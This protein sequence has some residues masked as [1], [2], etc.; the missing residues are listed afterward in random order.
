MGTVMPNNDP[1][2]Q[3]AVTN[4]PAQGEEDPY[5]QYA[6][7]KKGY[8][9]ELSLPSESQNGSSIDLDKAAHSIAMI[10]SSGNYGAIGQPVHGKRAIGKYQVME[11][12]IPEWSKEVLGKP[13]TVEEFKNS[14]E[15]QDKIVKG[16]I[17][18]L[19]DSGHSLEDIPS[20][21]LSGQPYK[22]N[23]RKDKVSGTNVP[24]YVDKFMG[25]YNSKPG[26]A[27]VGQD[28]VSGIKN[29]PGDIGGTFKN[30][31]GEVVGAAKQL[32]D[33]KR[34]F[35]NALTG[36]S[37]GGQ[38]LANIIPNTADYL[39]EKGFIGEDNPV[40]QFRGPK[41]DTPKVFG[42]Q[43]E[44]PGD[45]FIRMLASYVVP[46]KAGELGNFG[47]AGRSASRAGAAG[48]YSAGEGQNVAEGAALGP[49]MEAAFKGPMMAARGVQKGAS[50]L[51]PSSFLRGTASPED[52]KRNAE[53]AG[54]SPIPL[55]D[56][57]ESPFTKKAF[58]N[59]AAEI[60]GSGASQ[61]FKEVQENVNQRGVDVMKQLGNDRPISVDTNDTTKDLLQKAKKNYQNKKNSL[62]TDVSRI[63]E[64]EGFLPDFKKFSSLANK[65]KSSI[66]KSP[67]FETDEKLRKSFSDILAYSKH[68]GE[69]K[70]PYLSSPEEVATY[71]QSVKEN[72]PKPKK[73]IT[74][75]DAKIMKAN[76]Y[77][78]GEK[79]SKSMNRKD[80]AQG[81]LYKRLSSALDS[82]IKSSIKEKGSPELQD[83][84]AKAD[85]NYRESF[86][87]TLDRDIHKFLSGDKEADSIVR[88][89]IRPSK[90]S[91][92]YTR[93]K[94]I[95]EFL[96]E[97]DKNL[98]GYTYL[99][100][101]FE[102]DGT[103]NPKKLAQLVNSLGNRQFET[104]FP[105]PKD[106][107]ALLDYG[108]LR[109]MSE[110]SLNMMHNPKTGARALSYFLSA[111]SPLAGFSVGGL[112][113]VAAGAA[114]TSGGANLLTKYLTSP[115]VRNKLVEKMVKKDI[116]KE[117]LKNKK[118]SAFS[119][120]L[121]KGIQRGAVPYAIN[122]RGN[123]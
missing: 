82:D 63:A 43:D 32:A 111:L 58:E 62:Y 53:I 45:Q 67:L 39:A 87:K 41:I 121:T 105:N 7:N 36:L 68:M 119:K 117:A 120:Y 47:R 65:T 19:I 107:K 91:D 115:K 88:E 37:E 118:E 61:K 48:A 71:L 99:R 77:D 104:L 31:P 6:A 18:K 16:R 40:S 59:L 5:A 78:E 13:A 11:Q 60:P 69:K 72:P 86:S 123:S 74:L 8:D 52:L 9:M 70:K 97:K 28:I 54:N 42:L 12:N 100:T 106:R 21:W 96:P 66:E 57:T 80:T 10:E 103:L 95:Q 30:L 92:K 51:T 23:N 56:I 26:L 27:G 49:S 110:E 2:A 85:E 34:L 76:L 112:P 81:S 17:Q 79:L 4:Q 64:D 90:T 75:K 84:L 22:N 33:P 94:K 114:A 98:L 83:S 116:K 55:G 25:Y 93:I 109:G 108:K 89:V 14:P 24:E 50:S 3:Y 113:G 29:I 122:S 102:K 44:K 1:Y 46:G 101:A 73:I 20:I 15:L 35:Q 38:G